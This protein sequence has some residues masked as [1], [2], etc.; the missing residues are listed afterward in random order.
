MA[1]DR[2]STI[3]GRTTHTGG[4]QSS[5]RGP[6]DA[7]DSAISAVAAHCCRF[8][9]LLPE[10]PDT[11]GLEPRDAALAHAIHDAVVRRWLTLVYL[12][13]PHL[14]MPFES[15][16]P[17][18]QSV[19]L[20]G[21]AQLVFLDRIPPHAAVSES[22]TW[23]KR[24]IRR[25]AGGMVNA[26]LRRVHE[27]L[28]DIVPEWSDI[29]SQLLLADGRGQ[30]LVGLLLPDDPVDRMAVQVSAPTGLIRRWVDAQGLESALD[31]ALYALATPPIVLNAEFAEEPVP[32]TQPHDLPGHAVFTGSIADL[33]HM[34]ADRDDLWVQDAASGHAI[35]RAAA[36]MHP[37]LIVDLCAGRGTKTRQLA[38]AFPEAKI[39]ATDVDEARFAVLRS[40]F[41]GHDRVS[42]LPALETIP[43]A[44][45]SADLVL[46][47]VPCS[48]SGVLARRPEAK[49][50]FDRAQLKRLTGI[51]E[52]ILADAMGALSP[53]GS[54]LYSTCSLEP[55]E[56][57]EPIAFACET[58]GLSVS[59]TAFL[60][61]R[62]SPTSQCE[63]DG[64]HLYHDGSF[65][66]LLTRS[67]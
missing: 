46:L 55:E 10:T 21:A 43:A 19:L 47:D 57:A 61:P 27:S 60:W 17:G 1:F 40:V 32:Q 2:E 26:V 62:G 64:T 7:R 24:H 5:R 42:V 28:G 58:Y 37:S 35:R 50:R 3:V 52:Q 30:E 54:I 9:D 20:C 34:L 51:Q 45:A 12:I 41:A 49:Y 56:D 66:A 63:T 22:V 14:R 15:L 11:E 16:E 6:P 53:S 38:R 65:S 48:N 8:P 36:D 67:S 25:G 18:M 59:W 23:A 44:A 33:R 4:G 31:A 29:P 13:R 39:I